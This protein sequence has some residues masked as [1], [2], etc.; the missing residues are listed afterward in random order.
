[1]SKGKIFRS[2]L[3]RRHE[4]E[5]C[6]HTRLLS[7]EPSLHMGVHVYVEPVFVLGGLD[8]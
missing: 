8:D 4:E 6:N 7:K 3:D 1:M 2:I 5:N